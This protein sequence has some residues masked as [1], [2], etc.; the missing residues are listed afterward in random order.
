MKLNSTIYNY[1][2]N[3]KLKDVAGKKDVQDMNIENYKI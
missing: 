2:K 3:T 1:I